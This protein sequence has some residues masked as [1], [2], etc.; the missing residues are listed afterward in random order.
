MR[1]KCLRNSERSELFWRRV[2]NSS[3]FPAFVS[4]EIV[5]DM[6]GFF[7]SY[8]LGWEREGGR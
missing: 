3:S 6:G 8:L 5:S 2:L 1:L 7:L 4:L